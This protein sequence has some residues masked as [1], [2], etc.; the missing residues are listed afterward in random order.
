[1]A[2]LQST[3]C[4]IEQMVHCCP[5]FSTPNTYRQCVSSLVLGLRRW[6]PST[7]ALPARRRLDLDV[8]G[9]VM[10]SA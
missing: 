5:A 6:I 1:L 9:E 7:P 8:A 3:F 4:T 2:T 10:V